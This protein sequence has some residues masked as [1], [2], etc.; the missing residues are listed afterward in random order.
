MTRASRLGLMVQPL[1]KLSSLPSDTSGASF[2]VNFKNHIVLGNG[3]KIVFSAPYEDDD[4][5][6]ANGGGII[7]VA[8]EIT[9]LTVFREQLIVFCKTSIFV[10]NGNSVADLHYSLCPVT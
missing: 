4:F 5:T 3:K 9:G 7:N 1:P 2:I 6:V 8:D 10:L